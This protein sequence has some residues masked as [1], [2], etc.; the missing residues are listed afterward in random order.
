MKICK[1]IICAVLLSMLFPVL[2]FAAGTTEQDQTYSLTIHAACGEKN[3]ES[4]EI[5][6]YLI[7]NMDAN[8]ELT[9]TEK[10]ASYKENLNIRGKN[11]S[12]WEAAAVKLEDVILKDA[13]LKADVSA[14]TDKNGM[15]TFKNLSRGLYLILSD[16]VEVNEKVYTAAPFFVMLPEQGTQTEQ[17][18]VTVN[19]KLEENPVRADY[20]VIKVWE[21]SCH[22]DQRPKSIEIVLWCDGEEYDKVTLPE[23]GHWDHTW[24]E[25]ETGYKWSVTEKKQDGYKEPEITQKGYTFTVTNT[26]SKATTGAQTSS[27]LPQTGQLWWPVPLLICAGLLFIIVGLIRR[28]RDEHEK[29]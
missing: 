2:T 29:K 22:Q 16:S 13:S 7:S 14:K 10:F 26:C 19:M 11:D 6:G 23:N 8:G 3:I 15:T 18:D 21:D 17:Y 20:K 9:V 4:M 24:K 5:R 27:K 12:A 1:K 25:L 28:R